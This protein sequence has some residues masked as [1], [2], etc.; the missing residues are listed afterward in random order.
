MNDGSGGR[1]SGGR[2]GLVRRWRPRAGVL[3]IVAGLA[4]LAAGCG[5]GPSPGRASYSACMRKH[6]VTG[7]LASP[8]G[9]SM[10]TSMPTSSRN[11]RG[12]GVQIPAK[13]SAAMRACQSLAPRP[14]QGPG[15]G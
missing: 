14:G 4:M 1:G 10:P 7:A 5:S 12:R 11:G 6:G 2:G 3:V 9:M 13:D 8:P 15:P